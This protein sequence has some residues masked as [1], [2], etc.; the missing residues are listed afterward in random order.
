VTQVVVN[1]SVL[2]AK[3]VTP[4]LTKLTPEEARKRLMVRADEGSQEARELLG[5]LPPAHG[6][7][8]DERHADG[9]SPC[10]EVIASRKQK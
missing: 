6:E 7:T 5:L 3:Y 4:K 1:V 10:H 8:G 2:R 9:E